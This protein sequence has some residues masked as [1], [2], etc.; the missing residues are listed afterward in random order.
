MKM[1][2]KAKKMKEE[3]EK[4]MKRSKK[5]IKEFIK[6]VRESLAD[7]S[8]YLEK[9]D[10]ENLRLEAESAIEGLIWMSQEADILSRLERLLTEEH[11]EKN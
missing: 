7:I 9:E 4:E 10:W 6:N 8:R 2:R 5:A 3:I 1:K 11:E